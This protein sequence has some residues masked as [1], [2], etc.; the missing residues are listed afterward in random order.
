LKPPNPKLYTPNQV[1]TLEGEEGGGTGVLFGL[2]MMTLVLIGVGFLM[3]ICSVVG[4]WLVCR[5][6]PHSAKVHPKHQTPNTK[7]K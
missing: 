4:I 1:T 6:G 3:I 5:A 2:D 7:T